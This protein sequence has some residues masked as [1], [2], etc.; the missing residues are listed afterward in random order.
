MT[1]NCAVD[2]CLLTSHREP[3]PRPRDRPYARVPEGEATHVVVV[4]TAPGFGPKAAYGV[5]HRPSV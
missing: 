2:S 4:V 1:M 3:R 5:R